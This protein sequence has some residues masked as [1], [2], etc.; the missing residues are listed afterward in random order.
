MGGDGQVPAAYGCD[1]FSQELRPGDVTGGAGLVIEK[2]G[3]GDR[4]PGRCRAGK[5]TAAGFLHGAEH[6]AGRSEIIYLK[7][8]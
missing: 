4:Y 6:G 7:E 3:T 8:D 1:G 2:I 5:I